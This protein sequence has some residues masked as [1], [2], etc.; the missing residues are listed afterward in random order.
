[1]LQSEDR[2][3]DTHNILDY[4]RSNIYFGTEKP[5][6][7]APPPTIVYAPSEG[8]TQLANIQEENTLPPSPKPSVILP[9]EP[10]RSVGQVSLAFLGDIM[11]DR[12]VEQSVANNFEGDWSK[13]F[14]NMQI[15]KNYDIVFANLEGPASD[16]GED[17]RNL[18]SF[19]MNP[20][21]IPFLKAAK[22]DIVS[23][24]NNHIG[25][26]GMP[27]LSDTMSRLSENEIAFTGAGK[28]R[29]E[30]ETPTIIEKNGVK[31]GY[32]GFSDVGP[33]NMSVSENSPGI[34]LANDP[35]YGEIIS[36]AAKVTDML[37]VSIHF[38]EEYEKINN[39]R[40]KYLA[41]LAIDSGAKL[42][43]GTHPHVIQNTENY[44]GSPCQEEDPG[45][46]EGTC[47]HGGFIAYSLGNFIFDQSFSKDTM[48]GML[49]EATATKD[50][51]TK[52]SKKLVKLNSKFQPESITELK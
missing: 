10:A 35:R 12:G 25:D 24:A 2:V 40:Q 36:T 45:F 8:P 50:G 13:L 29:A 19:R 34:L 41:T 47:G 51:I 26:W 11:L 16:K 18:Y 3:K 22:I 1:M 38:G 30:A 43:I 52:I 44:K 28:N 46:A 32:L 4:L 23:L 20:A 42:V 39:S 14:D 7:V 15:L 5:F 6:A 33:D 31:V 17:R 48:Q 21:V 9:T 37:V 49:L 27:A